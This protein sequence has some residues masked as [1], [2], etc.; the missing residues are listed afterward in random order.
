MDL[1]DTIRWIVKERMDMTMNK[2]GRIFF[3]DE[4]AKGFESFMARILFV[5][6]EPGGSVGNDEVNP[7][8]L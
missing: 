5:V 4:V 1:G 2:I 8:L 3:F 6:N 7:P